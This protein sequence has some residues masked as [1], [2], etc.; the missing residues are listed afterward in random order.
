MKKEDV[1]LCEK[2]YWFEP[3]LGLCLGDLSDKTV[4]DTC[5]F[6]EPMDEEE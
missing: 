2:C 4:N 5:E 3:D 1:K 6:W